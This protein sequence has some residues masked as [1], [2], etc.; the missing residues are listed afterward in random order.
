MIWKLD[1]NEATDWCHNL[2]LVCTGLVV[3][4]KG[5]SQTQEQSIRH[6]SLMCIDISI[7]SK[8]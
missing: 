8:M 6:C 3:S 4:C 5:V 7:H 2:V 1:I